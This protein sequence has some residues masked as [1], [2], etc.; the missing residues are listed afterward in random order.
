MG[1]RIQGEPGTG[2][3]IQGESGGGSIQGEART[4]AEYY[5]KNRFDGGVIQEEA[6]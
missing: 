3:V 1:G 4:M 2:G 5:R 6:F